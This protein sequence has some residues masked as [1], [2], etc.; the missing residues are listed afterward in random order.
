MLKV[1]LA[2]ESWVKVA[3][4]TPPQ[5]AR[6]PTVD[7][8]VTSTK[9]FT[10]KDMNPGEHLLHYPWNDELPALGASVLL[11]PGI[12]WIRMGLPFALNHINLWLLR[13][14]HDGQSGWTLVDTCIDQPEPRAQWESIIANELGGLPLVRVLATHMHPDHVGLAH[15]LCQRFNAPLWMSATDYNAARI[16]SQSTTGF[17]GERAAAFFAAHGLTQPDNLAKIRARTGYYPSMVPAVPMSYRRMLDGDTVSICGRKWQCI[18]GYGHAPE[19]I[20]LFSA[21]N[22][23][24]ADD[25]VLIS[26]DMLLPRI[27]TN[28]AV[29][30]M[31]PEGNPLPLFLSS[32]NKFLPLPRHTL[33]LPSHGKPFVGIHERVAQLQ[34][35]HADRLAE[36]RAACAQGP[37]SAADV[38]KVMFKRE[39]DLH[40]TTFAMGESVAHL[41][42]L[43]HAGEVVRTRGDDGVYRFN[44]HIS[45]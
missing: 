30:E 3:T 23:T 26:G 9:N 35:H 12:Q 22:A 24:G 39:L 38:L 27:S 5:R 18:S 31:E 19:H 33:V 2:I 40:Q 37:T 13:D 15:W 36:V 44:P 21:A 28:V 43:W 11:R 8:D 16:A 20:S 25:P 14:E 32:I 42:A 10:T 41:H 1:L 4:V 45:P 29:Y 7:V 17:G 6:L 34:S